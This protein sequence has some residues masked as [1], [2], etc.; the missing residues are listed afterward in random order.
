[1]EYLKK[2]FREYSVM[3]MVLV[4]ITSM[5]ALNEMSYG[6]YVKV[7]Q[8]SNQ[9]QERRVQL[10]QLLKQVLDTE[11][12]ERGYV[13]TGDKDYLNQYN[14]FKKGIT[15]S[16]ERLRQMYANDLV[17]FADY[18]IL[19]RL[20]S[21]KLADME[22][23][24]RLRGL[25]VDAQQI[26]SVFDSN[27][28]MVHMN[29]IRDQV[30][31]LIDSDL[32]AKSKIQSE[33]DRILM[34]SRVGVNL[35]AL[36][37]LFAFHLYWRQ[38]QSLKAS[39]EEKRLALAAERDRLDGLVRVR[40]ARLSLLATYLQK[41]Q[42]TE[43]AKLGRELHDELGALLTAAK[44]DVARLRAQLVSEDNEA[45]ALLTH[46][47]SSIN[48]VIA[49]KRRIVEDLRPSSLADLGLL[50]SLEILARE[51][52]ERTE[53]KVSTD[54][55]EVKMNEESELTI[56]RIVQESLTNA[57]KY[58]QA[59]EIKIAV[60]QYPRYVQLV[61]Q[62]DGKGF[63]DALMN[64]ENATSGYGLAGMRHRVEAL[65]GTLQ[66]SSRPDNGTRIVANIPL[67]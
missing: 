13:L 44:L 34:I 14:E 39:A 33:T 8:E 4:A 67:M 5:I 59:S 51:F 22:V 20:V 58:A 36:L 40:T 56:Y 19:S 64:D 43:R 65:H 25:T 2:Q 46:L 47:S 48:S 63:D 32:K 42:E 6:R 27:T 18:E 24:V 62:D 31:K 41:A 50:T 21:N 15:L 53:V 30:D 12:G 57:A 55:S 45:D 28:G 7:G 35:T 49:I 37:A 16:L 38:T 61:V 17:G 29:E 60:R 10:Y 66:I 26:Q 11:T 3:L 1:M 52:E 54:L 23:A 9:L